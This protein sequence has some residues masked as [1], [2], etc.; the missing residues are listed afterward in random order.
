MLEI[1]DSYI[2]RTYKNSITQEVVYVSIIL[3]PSGRVTV[4]TPQ[5]CFGGKDYTL[6]KDK[7]AAIPI[8]VQI[9]NGA[10][11]VEDSFWRVNFVG[12]SL[13]TN[14]RITFYYAHSLGDV[15]SAM[16]NARWILSKSRYAYKIQV[17]AYAPNTEDSLTDP[18]KDFL[19]GTLP[20]IH[21]HL[22]L[23]KSK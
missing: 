2:S 6:E 18:V 8:T 22:T 20:V 11:T 19:K 4:H 9:D 21:E 14:N 17:Q 15:W 7:I 3:G 23:S 5:I 12:N 13:E 10:K 1:K 16:D